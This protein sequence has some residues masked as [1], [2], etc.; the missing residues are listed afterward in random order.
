M[1]E[2]VTLQK[3][4][5]SFNGEP[6]FCEVDM[7]I[8]P[9]EIIALMGVNGCGKST[10]LR[11]IA[12]ILPQT[13][14][15]VRRKKDTKISYIPDRFPKLPFKVEDYLFHMGQI[16]GMA[17]EAIKD[18]INRMF[19]TLNIPSGIRTRQIVKCS[20]GTIQ[21]INIMQALITTP[22]LLL[23]D[24]PF[25]GLDEGSVDG[26]LD[27]LKSLAKSGMA[28]ILSC[29]EKRL[30]QKLTDE[31]YV[32]ADGKCTKDS[33]SA[34]MEEDWCGYAAYLDEI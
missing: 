26:F 34:D 2:I 9:G 28:I 30:A 18:N 8:K 12:G 32:F 25:S 24:E 3:M 23:L 16:Q 31:I 7:G 19:E 33:A 27:L 4:G 1:N 17:K 21:K 11:I 22:D 6:I 13:T 5:K 15:E 29:H 20:K 10:L 14:G